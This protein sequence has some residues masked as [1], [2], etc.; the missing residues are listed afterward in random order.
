MKNFKKTTIKQSLKVLALVL[1]I[2]IT[3]CSTSGQNATDG[4]LKMTIHEAAFLGDLDALSSH[5]E[6]KSDLNQKDAYGS[7]PLNIAAVFGK[8]QVAELLIKAGADIDIK[9]S[10]GSTPLH[11]ASFFG[12]VDIAE[13]LLNNGAD[14]SI[15]NNFGS[16]ALESIAMPFE[17]MRPIYDQVSRDLGPLGLKL[18]YDEIEKARPVIVEM[19]K[20]NSK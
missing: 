18:D 2:G 1:T 20:A 6:S 9:S 8:P 13:M 19:I 7:A 4:T 10:D 3:S 14:V 16:T 5:I 15:R 12:R 17:N 11:S